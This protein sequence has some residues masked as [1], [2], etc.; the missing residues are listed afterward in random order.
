[1]PPKKATMSM[2]IPGRLI[3]RCCIWF[4]WKCGDVG[5]VTVNKLNVWFGR[6]AYSQATVY[7]WI[8]EFESGRVTLSDLQ[9]SGKPKTARSEDKVQE[10]KD[11]V[12]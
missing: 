12:N 6:N 5:K 7:R 3:Q 11:V 8:Q 9:R 10:C 4:S 1:M 2:E